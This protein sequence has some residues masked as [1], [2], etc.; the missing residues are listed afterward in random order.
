MSRPFGHLARES[1]TDRRLE[2]VAEA[3]A[4]FAK[5]SMEW[6]DRIP[7]QFKALGFDFVTKNPSQFKSIRFA[8]DAEQARR[9]IA[10]PLAAAVTGLRKGEEAS[11]G[12]VTIGAENEAGRKAALKEVGEFEKRVARVLGDEAQDDDGGAP[13]PLPHRF[14]GLNL[15]QGAG[16]LRE[17]GMLYY[18]VQEKVLQGDKEEEMS[19]MP[20]FTVSMVRLGDLADEVPVCTVCQNLITGLVVA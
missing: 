11:I 20:S 10:D 6:G 12:D 8:E 9:S 4:K 17:V 18:S 19:R 1:E 3:K 7:E 15:G 16:F 14:E 5:T 13:S 2:K